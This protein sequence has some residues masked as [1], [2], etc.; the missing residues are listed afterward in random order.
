MMERYS[1]LYYLLIIIITN[2]IEDANIL[3]SIG[4]ENNIAQPKTNKW[5]SFTLH[6]SLFLTI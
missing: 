3:S 2:I 5:F 6:F 4:Q 1:L